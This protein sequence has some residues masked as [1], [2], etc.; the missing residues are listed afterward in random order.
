MNSNE[1]SW[2]DLIK[3][4]KWKIVVAAICLFAGVA[5]FSMG[6]QPVDDTGSNSA[7]SPTPS[8]VI[9]SASPTATVTPT[10]IA[11]ASP[12]TTT[13]APAVSVGT[14]P[15]AP[16]PTDWKPVA[17]AFAK[18]WANP[19]AGQEAWLSALKPT[20]TSDLYDKFSN[21]N[22]ERMSQLEV[23]G[24]NPEKDDY[25]GVNARVSF[26]NTEFTIM[27]HLA[28]QADMTWLVSVVTSS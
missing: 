16:T 8:Y 2:L 13:T 15:Q 22:V 19:K 25:T 6:T 26:K 7:N 17:N 28:P 1:V 12:T 14:A 18:A 5:Y 11:T 27:I 9:P 4:H 21:T 3:E 23:S 24:I 20:V 10:P